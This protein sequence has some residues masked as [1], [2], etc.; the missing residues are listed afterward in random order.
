MPITARNSK[1]ETRNYFITGTDTGVGKTLVTALLALH[2]RSLGV[3]VGV[4]KPFATGCRSESGVLISEDAE[5]LK[6]VCELSD[7]LELINPARWEEPLAPLVAARRASDASDHWHNVLK[8]Y[9]VLRSR[10]EIVLVEGVGGVL[11]PVQERDGE[12]L[13]CVH[14]ANTLKLPTILVARRALGTIN[15]TLLT[16][17]ALRNSNIEIAGFIFCDAQPVDENDIAAQTSPAI[18]A[19]MTRLPILSEVPY[20]SDVSSPA[21]KQAASEY[22]GC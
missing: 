1:L 7:E 9:E 4:M 13:T 12:I 5:F 18:I 10:H 22:L 2:F 14:L 17:E 6:G 3:G 16:I 21:L 11:V 15:H 8:S 19:E 20:L